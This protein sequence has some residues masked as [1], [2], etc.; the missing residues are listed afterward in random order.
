MRVVVDIVKPKGHLVRVPMQWKMKNQVS[1]V[2]FVFFSVLVSAFLKES[3]FIFSI[4]DEP[5]SDEFSGSILG[6]KEHFIHLFPL[7]YN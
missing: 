7:V 5:L 6:K 4:L 2:F 1:L 3:I